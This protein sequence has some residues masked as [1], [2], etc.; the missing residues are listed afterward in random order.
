MI[1]LWVE[2]DKCDHQCTHFGSMMQHE[3]SYHK[4]IV[5]VLGKK[6][7]KFIQNN[8][9]PLVLRRE[10]MSRIWKWKVTTTTK[11]FNCSL[12]IFGYYSNSVI[13]CIVFE[14][15]CA[16]RN[17]SLFLSFDVFSSTRVAYIPL[18]QRQSSTVSNGFTAA[19]LG[20]TRAR[21]A[22]VF[23]R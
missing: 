7:R 14:K 20:L 23:W 6:F 22:F 5:N 15:Q 1:C 18:R 13:I 21:Y 10:A 4:N 9:W 12:L 2:M 8:Q 17:V 11:C 19:G 3:E 16:W